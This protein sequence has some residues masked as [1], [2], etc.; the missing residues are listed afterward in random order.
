MKINNLAI[1]FYGQY[2]SGDVC[3][4]HLKHIIDNIPVDNIDIFCSVKT[5]KSFHASQRLVSMGIQ[6]LDT[7]YI[8][9][10]SD[11]LT[12]HLEPVKINFIYESDDLIKKYQTETEFN[13]HGVLSP[14]GVIDALLL[15][16][17]HE[18]KNGVFYDA[19]ILMRYDIMYRPLDYI[20]KL[21]EKIQQSNDL[22]IWPNDPDSIIAPASNHALMG[23]DP[24][25]YTMFNNMINDLFIMFTGA[26]ADRICYEL[27]EYMNSLTSIYGNTTPPKY[28]AYYDY[29][30]FHVIFGKLGA[31]ISLHMIKTPGISERWNTDGIINDIEC[32]LINDPHGNELHMI[33]ARPNEHIEGLDPNKNDDFIKIGQY[34]NNA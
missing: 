4:P 2:R 29:M 31:P 6:Q 7:D 24:G 25:R 22:K 9:H 28:A 8:N 21:I 17:E 11:F 33:V 12:L 19:V 16:Q 13:N 20:P 14:A 30:N 1:C 15:K 3:I 26:G 10:I 27:I 23:N 5:S 34:W 32:R 18:A